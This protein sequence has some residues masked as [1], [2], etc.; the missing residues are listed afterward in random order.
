MTAFR[1]LGVRYVVLHGACYGPNQAARMER[2]LP[3]FRWRRCVRWRGSG[4]DTVFELMAS[5]AAE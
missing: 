1:G 4:A 3:A 2:D 5:S